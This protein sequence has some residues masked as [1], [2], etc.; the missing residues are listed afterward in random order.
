MKVSV[1]A[2]LALHWI[3]TAGVMAVA[4]VLCV[5]REYVQLIWL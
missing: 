5:Q 4:H 3:E 2:K 1:G